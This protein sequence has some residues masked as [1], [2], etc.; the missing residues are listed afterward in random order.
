MW[1]HHLYIG[2]RVGGGRALREVLALT[3]HS[4]ILSHSP[5][6]FVRNRKRNIQKGQESEEAAPSSTARPPSPANISS[7]P[8]PLLV[9]TMM[10]VASLQLRPIPRL[11]P[12]RNGCAGPSPRMADLSCR[13]NQVL[14]NLADVWQCLCYDLFPLSRIIVW[15]N[16]FSS[17]A[18]KK[19]ESTKNPP[20]SNPITTGDEPGIGW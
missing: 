19:K 17:M 10:A 18:A 6:A 3:T 20:K 12:A 1:N 7:S 4:Y 2:I 8:I 13:Y 11:L 15:W 5:T 14:T 16:Y 9:A